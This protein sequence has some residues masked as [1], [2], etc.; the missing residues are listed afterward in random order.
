MG[1]TCCQVDR[2]ADFPASGSCCR[3]NMVSITDRMCQVYQEVE[4]DVFQSH[5]EEKARIRGLVSEWS[6]RA[7]KGASCH[8][9]DLDSGSLEPGRY[10][11]DRLLR[12]LKVS[13]VD[14]CASALQTVVDISAIN[15][16]FADED[17]GSMSVDAPNGVALLSEQER[18][19]LVLI[20]YKAGRTRHSQHAGIMGILEAN[21]EARDLFITCINVLWHYAQVQ[22]S[23]GLQ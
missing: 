3:G 8:L 5:L 4:P 18:R 20:R 2:G 21:R 14:A 22:K 7:S 12:I 11:L 19:R 13:P 17:L 15:E 9:L 16:V 23:R 10:S 6:M 1:A